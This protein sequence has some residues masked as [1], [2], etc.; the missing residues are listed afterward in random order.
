VRAAGS[1]T[2]KRALAVGAVLAAVAAVLLLVPVLEL[3]DADLGVPLSSVYDPPGAYVYSPDAPF[4]QML[5]KGGLDDLWFLS[6][7]HLG[8]PL[9]QQVHDL[10]QSL[11]NLNLLGLKVLGVVVGD[12]GTTVNVFFVLTF[13]AVAATAYLVLRALRVSAPSS[14]VVAL[15]Y[16]FLPYHFARG[17][18]HLFL[19][20]YWVVP[21]AVLL[22]LR[23]VSDRPPFTE[24]RDGARGGFRI[25]VLTRSGA[26]WLLACIAIA[27][28]RDHGLL[29]LD[30]CCNLGRRIYRLRWQTIDALDGPVLRFDDD[31]FSNLSAI[32]KLYGHFQR[33][34]FIA[35]N[36]KHDCAIGGHAQIA[37][38]VMHPASSRHL[39][40]HHGTLGSAGGKRHAH[41][42]RVCQY[43]ICQQADRK[44]RGMETHPHRSNSRRSPRTLS[45][46]WPLFQASRPLTNV[47][48]MLDLKVSPSNGDHAQRERTSA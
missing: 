37:I 45:S 12:V 36:A 41:F 19:S 47:A 3:W 6:N 46:S 22:I 38:C 40:N 24:T 31:S 17:V 44:R 16:A 4:Y 18:P 42:R 2:S 28:L 29:A 13:A 1:D 43:W 20:A 30:A 21:L 32:R 33:P 23:V 7:D 25:R 26:W 48:A 10:P 5:A 39:A 9:G 15:L 14:F 34:G 35:T 11:D 8:W 27:C